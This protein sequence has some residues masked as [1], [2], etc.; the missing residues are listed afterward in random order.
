MNSLLRIEHDSD[1]KWSSQPSKEI[2]DDFAE[3]NGTDP[4][5]SPMQLAF[6]YKKKDEW[7]KCLGEQFFD[8]FLEREGSN[9]RLQ[10]NEW[11]FIYKL[12][13]QRFDNLKMEWKKWQKKGEEDD[14]AVHHRNS[15]NYR[16]DLKSKRRNARRRQVSKYIYLGTKKML[17]CY[18][19]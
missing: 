4:A 16:L 13:W 11:P 19:S 9:L 6:R 10:E 14:K 7:N 5:L 12:F 17:T 3:G 18:E 2:V 8:D 15:T 1:I